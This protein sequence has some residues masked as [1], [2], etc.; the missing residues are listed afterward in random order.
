MIT[1]YLFPIVPFLFVLCSDNNPKFK[2]YNCVNVFHQ[3]SG[4]SHYTNNN[5]QNM[6]YKLL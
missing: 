5:K 4:L 6:S 2:G 3:G 1:M